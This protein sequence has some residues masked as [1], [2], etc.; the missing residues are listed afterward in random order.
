MKA[1]SS[2]SN[3]SE[4]AHS[5]GTR[6]ASAAKV[7]GKSGTPA[8]VSKANI[9]KHAKSGIRQQAAAVPPTTAAKSLA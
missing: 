6:S 8:G 2:K 3:R 5:T 9:T 1:S 4:L 7:S